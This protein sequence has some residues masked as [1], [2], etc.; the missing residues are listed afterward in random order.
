MRSLFFLMPLLLFSSFLTGKERSIADVDFNLH[1]EVIHIQEKGCYSGPMPKNMAQDFTSWSPGICRAESGT[2]ELGDSFLR[3]HID[4]PGVQF[5]IRLPGLEAKKFY[6]ATF[7]VRNQLGKEQTAYLRRMYKPYDSLGIKFR[8]PR[9][10]KFQTFTYPFSPEKVYGEPN[11]QGMFLHL[12]AAGT[13]DFKRI[14][15]E[16][17]TK[18]E[19]ELLEMQRMQRVI[20]KP[21]GT[22]NFLRNST[23]P[24][25][26][27]SGWVP[28]A[29]NHQSGSI[30]EPDPEMIGP[31]GEAALKLDSSTDEEVGIFS[32]PFTASH[33]QKPVT[34]SFSCRG[35]GKFAAVLMAD[36]KSAIRRINFIPKPDVWQRI[37]MTARLPIQ[38]LAAVLKIQG[39]GKLHVDAFRV[40]EEG[41]SEYRM[42]GEHEIS[43]S[44]P[45][46]DASVARIQF[47]D[48]PPLI[49]YYLTGRADDLTVKASVT[50]L[51]GTTRTLPEARGKSGIIRYY[52]G[53]GKPYGQFRIEVQAFRNGKAVSV[54]NE[55][56]VTRLPRPIHWGKDAP[57][58]PFGIHTNQKESSMQAM[59]AGGF[60]W[61]RLHDGA[62]HLSCWYFVEPEKGKWRFADREIKAYR[63]NHLLLYGQLGGCPEWASALHTL[64]D[65]GNGYGKVYFTPL[66]EYERNFADYCETMTRRYKGVID[67]WFI[68]NEPWLPLFFHKGYDSAQK[69]YLAFGSVQ[70]N[71]NAYTHLLKLAYESAKKGNPECRITGFSSSR[72]STPAWNKALYHA[73][74]YGFC[75]EI[76][77]H[78]YHQNAPA[79]FP[80][81]GLEDTMKLSFLEIL[82]REGKLGKSCL[83]SEGQ[84]GYATVDEEDP[85]T[86]LYKHTIPWQSREN[87]HRIAEDEIRF[88][89]SHLSF[90]VKRIFLYTSHAYSSLAQGSALQIMLGADGFPHP[91]LAA[92]SAFAR[93]IETLRFVRYHRLEDGIFAAI[94]SNG[95][96]TVAVITGHPDKQADISC[97][98]TFPRQFADLYGNP[99]PRLFYRGSILYLSAEC[100][101]ETLLSH[102]RPEVPKSGRKRSDTAGIHTKQNDQT[103]KG[104]NK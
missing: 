89:L 81:D 84:S 62:K 88:L 7:I 65:F 28:L 94:F 103:M 79:G 101:P 54:V 67:D 51:Y 24:R 15:F 32:E 21:A 50:D 3:F 82:N 59:K 11:P 23:L 34:I 61:V 52:T 1:S 95:T 19:Y 93:R 74:A 76:D 4:S 29:G 42:S 60:N 99:I 37:S 38:R 57:D 85:R 40:A 41:K 102:L 33:P 13:I 43:L 20:R 100:S 87:Y 78:A 80:G 16:E 2:D 35:S 96:R 22:E 63:E 68:W 90:G 27:Q 26:L 56:V 6:K 83:M 10:R 58:S 9:S 72:G 8:L 77:Y 18:Q 53:E 104:K 17:I 69:R 36:N 14:R 91:G 5:N 64:P 98:G 97:S 75:D 44:L 31:S 25:G 46:S 49:H 86:G 12:S 73:G 39:K 92:M 70:D 55:M 71:A 48:E 30:V 66:P 47:E 45:D